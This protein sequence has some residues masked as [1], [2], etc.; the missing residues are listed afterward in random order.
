MDQNTIILLGAIA[1]I[2]ALI[3]SITVFIYKVVKHFVSIKQWRKNEISKCEV[4]ADEEELRFYKSQQ[5]IPT[6]GQIEG[7]HDSDIIKISDNRFLLADYLLKDFFNNKIGAGKKR[8]AILGGS[9][10]GKTTFSAFLFLKYIRRYYYRK[11]SCPIYVKYL[12]EENVLEDLTKISD[13]QKSQGI[14][15]LDALDE[16]VEAAE[17]INGFCKKLEEITHE[18]RIVVITS[19]T[20]FFPDYLSEPERWIIKSNGTKTKLIPFEQIFISPFNDNETNRYLEY[21][22]Q[23]GSSKY[24]KAKL[25]VNRCDDLMSRPM[26]LSYIDDLIGLD[27]RSNLTSV[28]LYSTIIEKWFEREKQAQDN[29]TIQELFDFSKDLAFF[30][31]SKRKNKSDSFV[32]SQEFQ[33]FLQ[34]YGY[35]H[36]LY[37]FK[38]KSL[39]NRYSNGSIK[40]CHKSFWEFFL[41]INSIEFPGLSFEAKSFEKAIS[42]SKEIYQLHL[43]NVNFNYINYYDKAFLHDYI[44]D[45]QLH[46]KLNE[47]KQLLSKSSKK[48]SREIGQCVIYDIWE[49]YVKTVFDISEYLNNGIKY[50]SN[51]EAFDLIK[52]D[53]VRRTLDENLQNIVTDFLSCFYCDN[54]SFQVHCSNIIDMLESIVIWIQKHIFKG[55]KNAFDCYPKSSTPFLSNTNFRVT[56]IEERLIFSNILDKKYLKKEK[57]FTKVFFK[58]GYGF[59]ENHSI[60]QAIFETEPYADYF[61]GIIKDTD[62]INEIVTLIN[63]LTNQIDKI[64]K[65]IILILNYRNTTIHFVVNH[66]SKLEEE[67][68]I[69][70]CLNNMIKAKSRIKQI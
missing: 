46:S 17:D 58:I 27:C 40:F 60:I 8:F 45:G 10:M 50:Y 34:E 61:L 1:T 5:F 13:P 7:P 39:I 15:I 35:N 9:G 44:F 62:D 67:S 43:N 26:I 52:R 55:S 63:E 68:I 12:G 2:L 21:K 70:N 22:Y 23:L 53:R 57:V 65:F 41:A 14:L 29:I 25:I 37:S 56:E 11:S 54:S 30:I 18:F 28:E 69:K 42:F 19:R 66:H 6:M 20:Q 16:S 38:V 51:E 48:V 31:Y 36:I 47:A 32:E 49:M 4:I 3:G 33:E 64:K 24:K 59:T